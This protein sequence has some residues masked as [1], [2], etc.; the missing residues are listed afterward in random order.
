MPKRLPIALTI[1]GSDSGGLAGLQA[2]LKT[3][4]AFG[5]HGLSAITAITAQNSMKVRAVHVLRAGVLLDQLEALCADFDIAA[6]KVG[7]LGNTANVR[8]VADWLRRQQPRSVVLDPVLIST[9]GS[10]L[11]SARALSV[12]RDELLPL[13]SLV[14]PN[15]PEA[16]ALLGRRLDGAD[17]LHDIAAEMQRMGARATLLKGGHADGTTTVRDIYVDAR[18]S[19]EFEHLRLPYTARGTGC[20]LASA[21]TAGLARN[22]S[23]RSAVRQAESYLQTCYARAAPIGRGGMRALIQ[24]PA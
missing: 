12:L 23:L 1:A 14:T 4:A 7:M 19:L 5:V 22:P 24:N 6:V 13:S 17:R 10:R 8:V 20:T 9:S 11:L 3:F 18:G 2:D 15:L 21:I 16:E